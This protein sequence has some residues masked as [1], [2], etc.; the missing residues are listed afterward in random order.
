MGNAMDQE[1]IWDLFT[2][3]LATADV[4]GIKDE[5]VSRIRATRSQLARPAIGADGRI[6]EWSRPW[7]EV[8]PGHRHMSHLYGLYPGEEWSAEQ[9]PEEM[10]A[11]RR[12]IEF[13]LANGGGHTGWSRAWLLNFFA[14][15]GDGKKVGESLQL[16]LAKSTLPNLLDDHPPFQI[17]GN[18]GATAGICEALVQ[19]HGAVLRLLPALPADW[20]SGSISGLRTRFGVEVSLAWKEGMIETVVLAPSRDVSLILAQQG[21]KME[22]ELKKGQEVHLIRSGEVLVPNA[23]AGE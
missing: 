19:S 16:Q 14:R 12:S 1:I 4:L 8:E 5:L 2:M 23:P 9:Q 3:T 15:L 20:N 21:Q 22:L 10:L 6:L 7:E 18:F 17:D 11:A 13:R